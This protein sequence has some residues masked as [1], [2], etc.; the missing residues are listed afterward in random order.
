LSR[1]GRSSS[2]LAGGFLGSLALRF[3]RGAASSFLGLALGFHLSLALGFFSSAA[4]GFLS[5]P[6]GFHL[7]LALG[8]F[9]GL[10]LSHR[11]GFGLLAGGFFGLALGGHLGFFLGE[12]AAGGM[13]G[14]VAGSGVADG[15]SAGGRVAVGGDGGADSNDPIDLSDDAGVLLTTSAGCSGG[16]GGRV[17]EVI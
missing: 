3:F 1:S 5:L 16:T 10:A 8:F 4:S 13:T 17:G 11:G 7:G 14:T 12:A 6:L 2:R 9:S 15:I